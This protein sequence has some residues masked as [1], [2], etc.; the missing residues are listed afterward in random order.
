MV[1]KWVSHKC[2]PYCQASQDLSE[3]KTM[4]EVSFMHLPPPSK[5]ML[6]VLQWGRRGL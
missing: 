3:D 1:L 2:V 6:T 4:A 5:S